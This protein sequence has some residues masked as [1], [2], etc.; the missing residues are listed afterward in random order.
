MATKTKK[1]APVAT[2]EPV[3]YV[4]TM[5]QKAE[6]SNVSI[7]AATRSGNRV[8]E[9]D[10]Y[11]MLYRKHPWVATCVNII[12]NTVANDGYTMVPQEGED[13]EPIPMDS[14]VSKDINGFLRS[15]FKPHMTWRAALLATCVDIKVFGRAFWRK[16]RLNKGIVGLE[17]LDP[18]LVKIVL[19]DDHT[20][21]DHFM[22]IKMQDTATGM[23]A[24]MVNEGEEIA[25]EDL[26]F[27][28]MG[29]GDPLLGMPSVLEPLD[30]TVALDLAMRRHKESFF[31][32]GAVAG[33]IL[34]NPTAT[35]KQIREAERNLERTKARPE[36]AYKAWLLM[37]DWKMLGQPSSSG[38]NEV[39]FI[40]G[41]AWNR[42]EILGVYHIPPGKLL[43][44][45]NALG[46]SGKSED[47]ATFMEN[48]VL[49]LEET[50][51]EHIT[52][53]IVEDEFEHEDVQ[54]VPKSRTSVKMELFAAAAQGVT[55]GMTGNEA[56]ELVNLKP[57][58][59]DE[60]D[61]DAPLFLQSHGFTLASEE[62]LRSA[63]D[64]ADAQGGGGNQSSD[65]LDNA[66]QDNEDATKVKKA[67]AIMR[68][69]ARG[70]KVGQQIYKSAK[71]KLSADDYAK[72][73]T[74]LRTEAE[75]KWPGDKAKQ[76][77][78]VYGRLRA[79]GWT[80]PGAKKAVELSTNG[81]VHDTATA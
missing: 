64:A 21:I 31:R 9:M 60:F 14:E 79:M 59:S 39:D 63:E 35:E 73:G 36:N 32:N 74:A 75:K 53:Y 77:E 65:S 13:Q 54:L 57:I 44:S 48:C 50:I 41:Q 80:Q 61:M 26:V 45:D 43:F 12:A 15:A 25:V 6:G 46:S 18:R 68:G 1:S 55:F 51:Y 62:P 67:R 30:L 17:R 4:T 22:L 49:P 27:F 2:P 5:G 10:V 78:Y 81:K 56:R 8:P 66:E 34:A 69:F 28:K 52:Q 3:A 58:E 37:G 24:I 71:K 19:N 70:L 33:T 40:K 20:E 11:W 16:K 38:K 72:A 23:V 7:E 47:D 42:D 29:G 76:D